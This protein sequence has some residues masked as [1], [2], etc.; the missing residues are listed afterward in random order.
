[1]D[2]EAFEIDTN[3]KSPEAEK[4]AFKSQKETEYP[5]KSPP[6]S[7]PPNGQLV[8]EADHL[9]EDFEARAKTKKFLICGVCGKTFATKRKQRNHNRNIT[10]KSEIKL[11]P[12]YKSCT[13]C[14]LT[15][16]NS[17][18]LVKLISWPQVPT[19]IVHTVTIVIINKC[20]SL[21]ELI[22]HKSPISNGVWESQ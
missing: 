12:H 19:N 13:V 16:N 20:R 9:K 21:E 22:G 18:D 14:E 11:Y 10:A 17:A 3:T 4:E 7:N 8:L 6:T 15:F 2:K 1:M 5:E